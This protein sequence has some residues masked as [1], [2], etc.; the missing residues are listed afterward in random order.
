[1]YLLGHGFADNIPNLLS[2]LSYPDLDGTS[3]VGQ[4]HDEQPA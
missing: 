4:P 2:A 1:M 3:L